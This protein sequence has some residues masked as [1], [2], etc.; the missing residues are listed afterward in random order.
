MC[1]FSAYATT[2]ASGLTMKDAFYATLETVVDQCPRRDPLHVLGDFNASGTDRDGYETWVGPHGSETVNQN[3]TK[4]LDFARSHGLRVASSW[5][6]RPQA[7]RWTRY[8]NAGDVAK[9]D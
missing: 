7:Q 5:F 3:S 4:F 8:S 2:E 1:R 6:Q 9:G